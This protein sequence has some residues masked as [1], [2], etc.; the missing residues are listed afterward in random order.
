MLIIVRIH[1]KGPI[2]PVWDGIIKQEEPIQKA[3]G[4]K[5]RLL[6][7]TKRLGFNR[8]ASLF[9]DLSDESILSDLIISHL[10]RIKGIDNFVIHH[11]FKPKF[12]PLPRDTKEY[13][14]FV[15]NLKV[16]T[17]HLTNVYKN[18]IDPN[19]PDGMKKVYFAFTFHQS[20]DSIQLSI[21][22][23]SEDVMREY[24][25]TV[26]ACLP[27]VAKTTVIPIER[28][29]S[30]ISYDTLQSLAAKSFYL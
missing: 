29:K 25:T 13:K 9:V 21:L 7:L 3:Y 10:A 16:E 23:K 30:F 27:G 14:R 1:S 18:L 15:I 8:E 24:V 2:E 26:I 20:S 4:E 12:Y 5:C 11:L 6:Y 22:S 19:I 28:S 17:P